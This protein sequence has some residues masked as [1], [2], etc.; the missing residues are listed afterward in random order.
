GP[1]RFLAGLLRHAQVWA[2]FIPLSAFASGDVPSADVCILF[3]QSLS[4]N[5]RLAIAR[6]SRFAQMIVV[7]SL[8]GSRAEALER[9]GVRPVRHGPADENG[10][11]LRV[12][13]PAAAMVIA[14]R[15]AAGIAKDRTGA[16]PAWAGSLGRLPEL[17]ARAD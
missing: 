15:L 7:S 6:R 3:S 13:G 8:T 11:L 5:A 9:L 14:A 2:Q 12:V 16:T 10:L 4:P 17:V 1:A